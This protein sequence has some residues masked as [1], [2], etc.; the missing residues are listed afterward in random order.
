ME[1]NE[2][3]QTKLVIENN[4]IKVTAS[5][6]ATNQRVSILSNPQSGFKYVLG[7]LGLRQSLY[8]FFKKSFDK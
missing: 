5:N 1:L 4:L 3:F 7:I 8:N 6:T 2:T